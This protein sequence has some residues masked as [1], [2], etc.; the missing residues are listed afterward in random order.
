MANP[1]NS[2]AEAAYARAMAA[3]QEG[4][5]DLAKRLTSDALAEDPHHAGARALRA[6]IDARMAPGSAPGG[7]TTP[8]PGA[9]RG[10]TPP[11]GAPE[12][13]SVDPT[14]LIDR[15]DDRRPPEYIEPTVVI[16]REDTPWGRGGR[17]ATPPP[18]P[19]SRAP[20]PVSEPTVMVPP[21]RQ[22]PPAS[23]SRAASGGF[24]Q[25]LWLRLKG[26]GDQPSTSRRPP[27][28]PPVSPRQPT[29]FW[30]PTTRGIVMAAAGVLLAA[31]FVVGIMALIKSMWPTVNKL[32]ITKPDNGTITG[33]GLECG[34]GGDTCTVQVRA[35]ETVEL[36]ARA[37]DKYVFSGF[38]GECP[39]NGRLS[40]TQARTCGAV[41]T[42]SGTGAGVGR[43]WPLTITKPEGGTIV[44]AGGIFCGTN[45]ASCTLT[46]PD[47]VPVSLQAETDSGFQFIAFTGDCALGGETVMTTARTC[48]AT[49]AKV[50][51]GIAQA[52]SGPKVDS[53]RP[54]A[55][56]PV[57]RPRPTLEQAAPTKPVAVNPPPQTEKPATPQ[58][59]QPSSPAIVP[60]ETVKPP[61]TIDN[62]TKP[63]TPVVTEE[64][65]AKREIK[66]L[67]NRYCAAVSTM[68][69]EAIQKVFP[70]VQVASLRE[71]FRQYKS[72]KCTITSEPDYDR[73]DVKGAGGAQL[74]VGMKQA[75]VINVG[76]QPAT[77]ETIVTMVVSRRD[78]NEP[79]HIDRVTHEAKPK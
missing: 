15:V 13:T 75:M 67:V 4:S 38:T 70:L 37:D 8:F 43:T 17:G 27:A 16:Q 36:Q 45:G 72:L 29:G 76:G 35:G 71:Q 25:L 79:W 5:Y 78:A 63:T 62:T 11:R 1:S 53:P 64:E 60:T 65:H 68:R 3:Y 77:A 66:D 57:P 39:Q 52:P 33:A 24:L 32:T 54:P 30:T 28:G 10:M 56:N 26:G 51:G 49:F 73:I 21:K 9:G 41:F 6:R 19:S 40:M 31:V 46:L 55:P 58:P 23:G 42:S 69:P 74:R 48:G 61:T 18:G 22:K 50:E 20:R 7:R 47:G 12:A 14:I 2:R 34:T 44:A 59:P